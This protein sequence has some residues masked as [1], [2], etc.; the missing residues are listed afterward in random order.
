MRPKAIADSPLRGAG[1]KARGVWQMAIIEAAGSATGSS[2]SLEDLV[3]AALPLV[4]VPEGVEDRRRQ[5]LTRAARVLAKEKD[6][7]IG[8]AG[9]RVIFYQ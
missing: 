4:E 6:G 9:Q 2:M 7:P 1:V 8:L 3:T 5:S